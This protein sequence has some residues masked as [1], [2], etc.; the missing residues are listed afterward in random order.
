MALNADTLA[1][2]IN[3]TIG[4]KDEDDRLIEIPEELSNYAKALVKTL[5]SATFIHITGNV[6]A[7][8][9]ANTTGA[10]TKVANIKATKG[11]IVGM[12]PNIWTAESGKGID[13]G[14]ET[15]Q[16]LNYEAKQSIKYIQ[17]NA[18]IVFDS[19][20]IKGT[21][22]AAV[23]SGT[24]TPGILTTTGGNGGKIKGLSGSQWAKAVQPDDAIEEEAKKIFDTIVNYIESSIEL[25]YPSGAVSG[26]FASAA[27]PLTAG[28]GAGGSIS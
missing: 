3:Q 8:S 12:L 25:K 23:I 24:P 15:K 20:K 26:G 14:E 7:T 16:Q 4:V 22:T 13:W 27:S 10:P 18:E 9:P 5:T 19:G 6:S 2:K 17:D 21:T 28:T 11:K 1:R